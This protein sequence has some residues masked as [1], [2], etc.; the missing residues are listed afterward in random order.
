ML[1]I[2][3]YTIHCPSLVDF[4]I[5]YLSLI[6]VCL[7]TTCLSMFLLGI[8]LYGTLFASLSEC[9]FPMLGKFSAITSSNIFSG[10][11]PLPLWDLC[12]SNGGALMLSER[13]LKLSS[14][15]PFFFILLHGSVFH[16]SV[17]QFTIHSSASFILLLIYSSVF[18]ISIIV[19]FISVCSL[20]LLALLKT[21]LVSFWPVPPLF[22]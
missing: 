5:F 20:N 11:L 14:F 4:K 21:F 6:F 15:H 19:L 16:Q 7:I 18:F 9:S 3:S 22:F 10:P 8:M 12:N 13:S 17:F 1:G 2:P